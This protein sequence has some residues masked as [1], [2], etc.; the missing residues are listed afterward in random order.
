MDEG[1]FHDKGDGKHPNKNPSIPMQATSNPHRPSIKSQTI[2]LKPWMSTLKIKLII[3]IILLV[4]YMALGA[5]F[6]HARSYKG[7]PNP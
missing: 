6:V 7:R 3:K 2:T 1:M 4:P 5:I